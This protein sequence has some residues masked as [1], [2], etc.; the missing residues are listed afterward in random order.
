MY[1]NQITLIMKNYNKII[2]IYIISI[3]L[4][5]LC[6]CNKKEI[7]NEPIKTETDEVVKENDNMNLKL[8]I[9]EKEVPVIWEDNE[10]VKALYEF[11]INNPLSIDMRM[12]GGFEQVGSL[13]T[14]LPRDDHNIVTQAGDI[15]L[16][17]GSQ[18]VIFYGSNSWTYTKLGKIENADTDNMKQLLAN[19]DVT[20]SIIVE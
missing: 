16:Y 17:N 5:V 13:N 18:I 9:D 11:A 6:A 19:N 8:F 4:F 12:Y 7:D 20:V 14:N 1:G 10:S 15:V 2:I 3:L